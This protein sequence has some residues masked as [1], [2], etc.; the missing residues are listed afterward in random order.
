MLD[1][2]GRL[3]EVMLNPQIPSNSLTDTLH[4]TPERQSK[5]HTTEHEHRSSLT[6]K[7]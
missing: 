5:F 4:Y 1:I 7:P 2:K 3:P 6:R